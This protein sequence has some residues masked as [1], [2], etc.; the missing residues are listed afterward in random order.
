E[1][2][3][4]ERA[5]KCFTTRVPDQQERYAAISS[6]LAKLQSPYFV[7]FE[8]QNEGISISGQ[9]YPML[10]MDWAHGEGLIPYIESHLSER[11]KLQTLAVRF[12]KMM[13][14]LH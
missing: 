7:Q 6:T 3:N 2:H 10:K 9:K 8:Y 14:A 4:A 13:I 12:L 5:V 11:Q 1:T